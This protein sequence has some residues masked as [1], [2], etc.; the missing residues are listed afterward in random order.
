MGLEI[1]Q[2]KRDFTRT[3]EP[4]GKLAKTSKHRF[5]CQEHHASNLHFDFRLEI[6]G[7]LKSWSIRK[8]P[9]MDPNVRRLAVPTEDHPVEYLKFQ[10]DIP[11][12]N[13]GAGQHR[14][15]DEG[16]YKLL[17]GDNIETQFEKG[18]LK[19]ELDGEKLKGT[20]ALFRLG[21]RD[22]WLLIKSKDEHAE[23]GWSLKLL[24]P[25]KYGTTEIKEEAKTGSSSREKVRQPKVNKGVVRKPA[26]PLKGEK[27]PTLSQLLKTKDLKGNHRVKVGKYAVDLTSLDRVYWPDEGYTKADLIKYYAAVFP[28][29]GPYLKERPLIMKR[30]PTGIRGISFHQHDVDEVPEFVHTIELE[31]EDENGKHMVD[32]VVCDNLETH[33][34]LANLGAIE[35]HPFHSKIAKLENP[36]WFVF[37]LDP[38]EKVSFETICEVAV[39]ARDILKSH[40][41]ESYA[42]TSGSRGMHV[43]V[44]VKPEYTYQ[45]IADFA[46][47]IAKLVA[48]EN[49]RSATVERGKAKRK[50]EQIYV[51][52]LQN[53]YGKSVVAP[54]SVRP[55]KG[56]TVSAPLDWKEVDKGT[57][58]IEDFTITNMLARIKKKGEIFKPVLTKRQNLAKAFK[59]ANIRINGR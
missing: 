28:Y 19:L 43:Y 20:F 22:Q 3:P 10:G 40:E 12:G 9:S 17:D 47:T 15:W 36:T 38:G 58:K 35:R 23:S 4:R 41:L 24:L 29:I 25:D 57:I 46:A 44:P 56:A 26:K 5:V 50:K 52:H 42:K 16:N 7:V 34:W 21:D 32:Y 54:Y 49:P 37:D 14:I 18:K 39:S 27:L 55:K 31:A 11:K 8:G 48:D 13:Y 1:Y 33:L 30:Y 51:D 45:Q 6:G 59:K 53:S 2:Q